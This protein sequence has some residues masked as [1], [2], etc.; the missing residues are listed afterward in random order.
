MNVVNVEAVAWAKDRSKTTLRADTKREYQQKFNRMMLMGVTPGSS[1]VPS[2]RMTQRAAARY[3]LSRDILLADGAGDA[4]KVTSLWMQVQT[5]QQIADDNVEAYEAGELVGA[6]HKRNS[7]KAS[8][9]KL[10]DNWRE[11]LCA[12]MSKHKHF[13]AVKILACIGCRPAE[14]DMG[15]QVFRDEEG[16]HFDIQGAKVDGK[17][18]QRMRE[19]TLPPDHPVAMTLPDGIYFA[20]PESLTKAI[21]RKAIK[22]GFNG[23]SAYSFRHQFSSD[24][25]TSGY[26]KKTIARGMGHQ[27][28][29]TQQIYGNSGSGRPLQVSIEST[30]E[31]RVWVKSTKPKP[32]KKSKIR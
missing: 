4:N 12:T 1:K 7:K 22:L 17:K 21:T 14:L 16:I 11:V 15:V 28:T 6:S 5:I 19:I 9:K 27:S 20:H 25:K 23:V 26:D 10:P 2:T 24:L 29:A 3:V 18:G 30:K 8:I 13:N 32:S 31:P